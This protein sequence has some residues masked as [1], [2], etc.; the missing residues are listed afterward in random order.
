M[1]LYA[2]QVWKLKIWKSFP[3]PAQQTFLSVAPGG[4]LGL[5]R[6]LATL[7]QESHSGFSPV[8]PVALDGP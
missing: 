1:L 8:S 6:N 7:R 4:N 2:G 5:S 3:S